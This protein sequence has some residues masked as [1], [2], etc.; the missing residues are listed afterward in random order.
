VLII[1]ADVYNDSAL[2]TTVV[3]AFTSNQ[4]LGAVPGNVDMPAERTGLDRDSVLNVSSLLTVDESALL[5]LV[6]S[7]DDGLL[8]QVD[9]GLRR[10]L[11]L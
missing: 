9:A 11:D 5:E 8:E 7:I 4:R 2:R 6:G 3:A 1:Q 10:V